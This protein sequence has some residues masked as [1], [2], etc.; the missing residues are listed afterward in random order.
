[1]IVLIMTI[2]ISLLVLIVLTSWYLCIGLYK[3]I[4]NLKTLIMVKDTMINQL[5]EVCKSQ[6]DQLKDQ[7][8]LMDNLVKSLPKTKRVSDYLNK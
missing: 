3:N 6:F 7:K 1:M 2:L 5:N 4:R 8:S